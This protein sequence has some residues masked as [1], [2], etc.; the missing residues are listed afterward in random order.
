MRRPS[1]AIS[2]SNRPGVHLG[3]QLAHGEQRGELRLGEPQARQL[4]AVPGLTALVVVAAALG[5]ELDGMR[6]AL[7]EITNAALGG[8]LGALELVADAPQRDRRL[9]GRGEQAVQARDGIESF[10]GGAPSAEL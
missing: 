8:G 1:G 2:R 10:H 5:V 3:E 7:A 9:M 6:E 4:E